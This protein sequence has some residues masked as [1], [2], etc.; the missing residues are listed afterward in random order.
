MFYI[1]GRKKM[2]DSIFSNHRVSIEKAR[3]KLNWKPVITT[4]QAIKK[5][6]TK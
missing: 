1:I 5:Y 3:L 6:F 4:E 2:F